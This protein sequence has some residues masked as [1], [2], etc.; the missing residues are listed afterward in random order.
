MTAQLSPGDKAAFQGVVWNHYTVHGRHD[1]PWRLSDK[2]DPET[3]PNQPCPYHVLVSELMLQQTQVNRVIPKF[4]AFI[5]RYPTL[6]DVADSSLGEVIALWSGL[7]YNRR[8]KFL[9]QTSQ[10]I[11]QKYDGNVPDDIQQLV[12][13][14]GIGQNTAGAIVAYAF[15]KPAV[16]IETNIRTVYFHHFFPG[17]HGIADT[18]LVPLIKQTMP[19][20]TPREWYWALM[21]Y[22]TFLKKHQNAAGTSKHFI[23]QSRFEGSK[24]QVRGIVLKRLTARPHKELEL[25]ELLNDERL[26]QVLDELQ[27]EGFIERQGTYLQLPT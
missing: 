8:A 4:L 19:T 27:R 1:L 15:N 23:K 12:E 16:F 18:M 11:V 5:E 10:Q 3:L 2:A 7:G 24:R 25:Y 17:E 14:P 9:W 21:D 22:G 13:L 20:K 26:T 6:R